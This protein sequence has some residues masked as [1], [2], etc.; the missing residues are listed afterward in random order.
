M[1]LDECVR[2]NI[3]N[4]YIDNIWMFLETDF[5]VVSYF[6]SEKIKKCAVLG[7]R[8]KVRFLLIVLHFLNLSR[9]H[10][11]LF[12]ILWILILL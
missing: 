6:N 1:E 4:R 2:K 10:P 9:Y 7:R 8:L 12:V 11:L 5:D 3:K